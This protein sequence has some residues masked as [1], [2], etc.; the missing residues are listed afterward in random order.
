M[1]TTETSV[2]EIKYVVGKSFLCT[3][4]FKTVFVQKS[5]LL[6]LQDNFQFS[7]NKSSAENTEEQV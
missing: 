4:I 2:T 6:N 7:L 5:E 1:D 3:D